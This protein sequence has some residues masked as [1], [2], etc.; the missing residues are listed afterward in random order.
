MVTKARGEAK[1]HLESAPRSDPH[2]NQLGERTVHQVE[3]E[4]RALFL[5]L[6]ERLSDRISVQG[7]VVPWLLECAVDGLNK[8]EVG[9]VKKTPHERC[10]GWPFSGSTYPFAS[11]VM[12]RVTGQVRGGDM[13]PR[14]SDGLFIGNCTTPGE[15][16]C[17][18][19]DGRVILSFVVGLL[20]LEPRT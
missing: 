14:W 5:D 4:V 13:R 1:T 20:C 16:I 12:H 11:L 19:S 17:L 7:P 2:G 15:S 18:L 9:K 10:C 3:E 6:E 8:F